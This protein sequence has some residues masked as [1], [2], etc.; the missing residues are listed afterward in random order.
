MKKSLLV[1]MWG[2]VAL[3]A[4]AT[5]G[6][7]RPFIINELQAPSPAI[8]GSVS[9]GADYLSPTLTTPILKSYAIA[10]LPAAGTAGRLARV[11]DGIRGIWKD[12]GTAWVS[13][14]GYAD[15]ADFGAVEDCATDDAAAIQ[16]AIDV[17]S[18]SAPAM[19]GN[20]CYK[21]NTALTIA[22]NFQSLE[23]RGVASVIWGNHTG[24]ALQAGNGSTERIGMTVKNL[25][26]WSPTGN[27]F[28]STQ[29]NK[30][31]FEN[32][33]AWSAGNCFTFDELSL[34]N[35]IVR[36]TCSSNLYAAM[37]AMYPLLPAV[38]STG[39]GLRIQRT[40]NES[41]ALTIIAPLVEG[42]GSHGIYVTGTHVTITL[43]NPVSEG[44]AGWG[45]YFDGDTGYMGNVTLINPYSESNTAGALYATKQNRMRVEG[46][47]LSVVSGSNVSLVD[48]HHSSFE[49]IACYDFVEDSTSG[50]NHFRS[51]NAAGTFTR[52]GA[53][54]NV[55]GTKIVPESQAALDGTFTP[56]GNNAYG[57][58]VSTTLV[59]PA[60]GDASGIYLAPTMNK[61][62]SGTHADFVSLRVLP[63]T[64]GAGAAAL[65][66]ASTVKITGAPTGATNNYA[67]WVDDGTT[68]LDGLTILTLSVYANNAAAIA[69]GLPVGALYRTG[70]DPDP[71]MVVH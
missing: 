8:T 11:T 23:G 27:G 12:T 3:L 26:L 13:V 10:S 38:T 70:A 49:Q 55:L 31:H 39:V 58:S 21:A 28:L 4:F 61:A 50:E 69:G 66:N 6:Y 24:Y 2:I 68:R 32:I 15:V 7:T 18:P 54:Q 43:I 34:I 62:G 64:I 53:N 20:K 47:Q 63:P 17:S 67:V 40:A 60:V 14:T 29:A 1:G 45:Y 44:N 37:R 57:F 65:T 51:I 46:G 9:G 30:S 19:L 48:V 25:H 41:N 52:N 36:P 42:V 22:T 33:W 16:A 71:V 59:P 5:W 56:T 35:T